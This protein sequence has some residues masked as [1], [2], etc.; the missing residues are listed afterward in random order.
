MTFLKVLVMSVAFTATLMGAQGLMAAD[1]M[2]DGL[3]K[4]AGHADGAYKP[5]SLALKSGE[6]IFNAPDDYDCTNDRMNYF[7]LDTAPSATL[8]T[9]YNQSLKAEGKCDEASGVSTDGWKYTIKTIKHPT[10]TRWIS[11]NELHLAE[12]DDIIVAGVVLV[13]KDERGSNDDRIDEL[14]CVKVVRSALP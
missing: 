4:F 14:S 12:L 8:I 2:P 3:I 7:Q 9:F 10:T 1:A 13:S 6:Y 11:I 5:C